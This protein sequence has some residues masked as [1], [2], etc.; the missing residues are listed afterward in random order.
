LQPI[1]VFTKGQ[2]GEKE[3]NRVFVVDRKEFDN[4]L[5]NKTIKDICR[6]GKHLWIELEQGPCV[7]FHFGMTGKFEIKNPDE[8]KTLAP[9]YMICKIQLEDGTEIAY[10]DARRLGRI[11]LAVEP[12][13][14]APIS[15]L[16]DDP[17]LN[18]PSLALFQ[19]KLKPFH[20]E[21][22]ALLLDQE[23]LSG[24]GNWIADEVLY[25]AQLHPKLPANKLGQSEATKLHDSICYVINTA[26]EC[27]TRGV[28]YPDN[29]LL[30]H[31]SENRSVIPTMPDGKKIEIIK[32]G[33]RTSLYVPEVQILPSSSTDHQSKNNKKPPNK[34]GPSNGKL[35]TRRIRKK[36]TETKLG[37]NNTAN[38]VVAAL[39]NFITRYTLSNSKFTTSCNP[40]SVT[41]P[42]SKQIID[43]LSTGQSSTRKFFCWN[44]IVEKLSYFARSQTNPICR[45]RLCFHNQVGM[46]SPFT[47]LRLNSV[48]ESLRGTRPFF[49]ASSVDK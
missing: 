4:K 17:L 41:K 21:I 10:T 23:F 6:K 16:G 38:C 39:N 2:G 27:D 9:K 25:H 42:S 11:G 13:K 5:R 15:K 29:W 12:L 19:Q 49:S 35:K 22:K 7:T 28:P 26:I 37:N 30:C 14:E 47:N 3:D 48:P 32:S 24:I 40:L 8:N 36:K 1:H 34:G 43:R 44:N 18:M 45:K 31:R 20:V 33:G 46:S